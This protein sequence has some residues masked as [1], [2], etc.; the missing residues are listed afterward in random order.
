M[1][2]SRRSPV[3]SLPLRTKLLATVAVAGTVGLTV[4]LVGV[5]QLGTLAQRSH[6]I[7]AH[8]LVP[9]SELAEIRRN[10]LQTRLDGLAD[11]VVPSQGGAEHTAYLADV[12]KVNAAV[13]TFAAD[14]ALS[15]EDRT[16]L[17]TM[18]TAWKTYSDVVGHSLLDLA[19]AGRMAD[20]TA[21]RNGTVKPVSITLNNAL[22]ALEKSAQQRAD[23]TVAAADASYQS[24]RTLV[25]ALLVVGLVLTVAI[26][27]LVARAIAGP[28]R[29]V[30]DGL[31]AMAAGDLT[32]QVTVHSRDEV[33]QMAESLN[34]AAA[35]VRETVRSAG[36]LSLIHI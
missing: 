2:S 17:D 27:L 10:F 11:E 34:R 12:D 16:N 5:D 24:A 26:A 25:L 33:G 1:P 30:R 21:L 36:E 19:R 29:A 18:T 7:N 14:P 35:S 32:V 28:V 4:G 9:V 31:E 15:A 20:F 13:A 23:A 22:T 8:A 6:E 3:R